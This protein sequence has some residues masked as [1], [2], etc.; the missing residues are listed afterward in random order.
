MVVRLC[1]SVKPFVVVFF[2]ARLNVDQELNT[3]SLFLE[4]NFVILQLSID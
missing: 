2:K 3:S 4:E 1:Y